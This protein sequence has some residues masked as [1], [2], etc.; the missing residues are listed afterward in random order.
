MSKIEI[1][2]TKSGRVLVQKKQITEKDAIIALSTALVEIAK[3]D[4]I[5]EETIIAVIS[6]IYN[7]NYESHT[8]GVN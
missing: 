6:H 4:N 2:K 3:K 7:A 1:T 5:S 8:Y